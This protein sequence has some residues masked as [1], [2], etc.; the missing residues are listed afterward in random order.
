MRTTSSSTSSVSSSSCERSTTLRTN[1]NGR[2]SKATST[3]PNNSYLSVRGAVVAIGLTL[4][5]G[6]IIASLKGGN[7]VITTLNKSV[8]T[9]SADDLEPATAKSTLLKPT[10]TSSADA[11]QQDD[12]QESAAVAVAAAPTPATVPVRSDGEGENSHV[13]GVDGICSLLQSPSSSGLTSSSSASEMWT[14]N[15]GRIWSISQNPRAPQYTNTTELHE[16]LHETLRPSRL[17]RGILSRPFDVAQGAALQNAVK[18]VERK[19][20]DDSAPPLRIVVLG[21]SVTAGRGCEPG[22]RS[23]V[24]RECAWPRRFESMVNELAGK[25]IVRVTNLASGGTS[26]AQGIVFV[27][28][29][30]YNDDELNRH[31]P[32][33]CSHPRTLL[34][35]G[36]QRIRLATSNRVDST[37]FWSFS[38]SSTL[39]GANAFHRRHYQLVLNQRF[40]SPTLDE[41]RQANYGISE[42][43][44][45]RSIAGI[46]SIC[47]QIERPVCNPSS[48]RQRR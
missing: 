41:R 39:H 28:Y 5:V 34:R 1:K 29:W 43:Q 30:M 44:D 33:M 22:S 31:G 47:A 36:F 42:G 17:R 4:Q 48:R 19:M 18:I 20:K 15:V 12:N 7:K 8:I 37:H 3:H 23:L 25:Q 9:T 16:I 6:I 10:S 32:G 21:G 14:A 2:S 46:C 11:S 26:T 38:P 35:S 45:A 13:A 24:N 40:T 27:K